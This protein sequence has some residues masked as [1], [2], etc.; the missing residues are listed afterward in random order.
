[1]TFNVRCDKMSYTKTVTEKK[2]Y[3][4]KSLMSIVI[5]QEFRSPVTSTNASRSDWVGFFF[6][7]VRPYRI[8]NRSNWRKMNTKNVY[9]SRS[10]FENRSR[11][12]R[13]LI[14]RN[15]GRNSRLSFS[16]SCSCSYK[17]FSMTFSTPETRRRRRQTKMSVRVM[18][19]IRL[20]NTR[21]DISSMFFWFI[22]YS[23]LTGI[24]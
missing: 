23:F 12:S 4:E 24:G 7:F 9:N 21:D 10:C 3:S 14:V 6:F 11:D 22:F 13:T 15:S 8:L 20:N 5:S 18:V 16:S 19:T 2:K 17:D 1:M